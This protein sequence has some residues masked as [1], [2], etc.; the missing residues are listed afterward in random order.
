MNVVYL[1]YLKSEFC[2]FVTFGNIGPAVPR[3]ISR[4]RKGP[5][6]YEFSHSSELEP[7]YSKISTGMNAGWLEKAKWMRIVNLCVDVCNLLNKKK[8]RRW[9]RLCITFKI[10]LKTTLS[11][12]ANK[13][14]KDEY[15]VLQ[16]SPHQHRSPNTSENVLSPT[17]STHTYYSR[18]RSRNIYIYTQ[19]CIRMYTWWQPLCE[20][21]GKHIFREM[22]VSQQFWVHCCEDPGRG[23]Q[24]L[25][26]DMNINT[27]LA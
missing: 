11:R 24:P 19:L 25:L 23:L 14:L 8:S 1:L 7:R 13:Q 6:A 18:K 20:L 16:W 27:H 21:E 9:L 12:I 4:M 3:E 17:P 15:L 2:P 5:D 10:G 26:L 22:R